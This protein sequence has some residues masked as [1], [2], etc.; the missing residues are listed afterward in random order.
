M[1]GATLVENYTSIMMTAAINKAAS[2]HLIYTTGTKK[3]TDHGKAFILLSPFWFILLSCNRYADVNIFYIMHNHLPL[4][5]SKTT[6]SLSFVTSRIGGNNAS[7]EM[8]NLLKL[9]KNADYF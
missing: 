1:E 8:V 6:Y 5:L 7:A 9:T 4:C 2:F 3:K